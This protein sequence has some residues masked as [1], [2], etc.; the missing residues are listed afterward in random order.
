MQGWVGER[1]DGWILDGWMDGWVDG[2]MGGWT[3]GWMGGWMY[4]WVVK[5]QNH[6]VTK[7]EVLQG[8][9]VAQVMKQCLT[10]RL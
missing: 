4:G 2:W 10:K 7:I 5:K 6:I 8:T 9:P 3:G 1:V